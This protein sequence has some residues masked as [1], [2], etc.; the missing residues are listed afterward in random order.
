LI[1]DY[2]LKF[3]EP[4]RNFD[5]VVS[6]FL[7]PYVQLFQK[8]YECIQTDSQL[9]QFLPFVKN[10]DDIMLTSREIL[11]LP[12]LL[13]LLEKPEKLLG[14]LFMKVV[15]EAV[16]GLPHYKAIRLSLQDE[17]SAMSRRLKAVFPPRLSEKLVA[18]SQQDGL[19][20][21]DLEQM[22]TSSRALTYP[23]EAFQ[24]D[25]CFLIYAIFPS[26]LGR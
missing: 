1:L 7:N 8:I 17:E 24:E 20:S 6:L 11:P 5:I 12:M 16:Q 19:F 26:Y 14:F 10:S 25:Q 22:R 18:I 21:L 15:I 3:K 13:L 23:F 2:F 9:Q 4:E